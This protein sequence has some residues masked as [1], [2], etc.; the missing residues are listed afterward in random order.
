MLCK[1]LLVTGS[2]EGKIQ[3]D[4]MGV[5]R[6]LTSERSF[7][8]CIYKQKANPLHPGKQFRNYVS[9][10]FAARSSELLMTDLLWG[11]Y[12]FTSW[13]VLLRIQMA[14]GLLVQCKEQRQG[15]SR[16]WTRHRRQTKSKEGY[17]N[18]NSWIS[19]LFS[20][21]GFF[22]LCGQEWYVYDGQGAWAEATIHVFCLSYH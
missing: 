13:L 17:V 15:G 18:D 10:A 8:R 19:L 11:I 6:R 3:H 2:P 16:C 21:Y 4:R 9:S 1:E 22:S 7:G 20:S 14:D 12:S 5:F